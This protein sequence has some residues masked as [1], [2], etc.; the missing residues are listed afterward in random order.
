MRQ[1]KIQAHLPQYSQLKEN[2]RNNRG[3]ISFSGE[4]NFRLEEKKLGAHHEMG[5]KKSQG[6][7]YCR[8]LAFIH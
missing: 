4:G 8:L 7:L 3:R 2:Q 5:K 6:L 1:A